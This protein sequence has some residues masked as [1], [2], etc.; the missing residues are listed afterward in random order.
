MPS[1]L[2]LPDLDAVLAAS[3]HMRFHGRY[4]RS[5]DLADIYAGVH[6]A[7][8]IDHFERGGNGDWALSNRLYEGGVL[9]AVLIAERDV[10]MGRW[11]AAR[12]TGVLVGAAIE[13]ELAAF[14][15][16]L[17]GPAFEVLSAA[18]RAVPASNHV[19]DQAE[20]SAVVEALAS[21]RRSQPA[22][23]GVPSLNDSLLF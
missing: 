23:G 20:C 19:A 18:A 21:G 1:A 22:R 5:R 2:E 6:F 9:G 4:D 14:F 15:E 12:G 3:P 7:W 8:S 10:A 17:D 11:L 13:D 16:A